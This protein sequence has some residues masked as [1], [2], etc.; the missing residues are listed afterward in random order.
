MYPPSS[1][2]VR[3]PELTVFF[4]Q[5][6]PTS[7]IDEGVRKEAPSMAF[8]ASEGEAPIPG[9]GR[10][11][12]LSGGVIWGKPGCPLGHVHL[13]EPG[14][15]APEGPGGDTWLKFKCTSICPSV[16][17]TGHGEANRVAPSERASLRPRKELF[18][19]HLGHPRFQRR[20]PGA[21]GVGEPTEQVLLVDGRC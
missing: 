15:A 21:G 2:K 4:L 7:L 9:G 1:S 12:Q 18:K 6:S 17:W 14:R 13:L 3:K 8:V 5:E 19:P 11:R 16:H 10:G 20:K